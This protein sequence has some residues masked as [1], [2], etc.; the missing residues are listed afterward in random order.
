LLCLSSRYIYDVLSINNDEF[1][2]YAIW[3]I[4]INIKTPQ[5]V[6]PMFRI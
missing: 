2:F 5:N 3:H 1:H 6:L 4:L